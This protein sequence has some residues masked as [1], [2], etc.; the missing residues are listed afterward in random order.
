MA[1]TLAVGALA[2][3]LAATSASAQDALVLFK[4]PAKD[5]G[6]DLNVRGARPGEVV[7]LLVDDRPDPDPTKYPRIPL[8]SNADGFGIVRFSVPANEL[9][10]DHP[11]YAEAFTAELHSNPVLLREVPALYLLVDD[12]DQRT[13]VLRFD[14]KRGA[15]EPQLARL[16]ADS[17][18]AIAQAIPFAARDGALIRSGRETAAYPLN[19]GERPIDL[20]AS[21]DQSMLLALTREDLA[22]GGAVLR[23]RLIE[24][25]VASHEIASLEVLRGGG[26]LVSAWLVFHN[27]SRRALVAASD[28]AIREVV[29]G[30][31]PGKGLT[32]LP[33]S[34]QASEELLKVDIHGDQVVVVTRPAGARNRRT[35]TS[36]VLVFDLN[37]R[38]NPTETLLDAVAVDFEVAERAGGPAAFVALESG[39]VEVVPLDPDGDRVRLA[40]PE[41]RKLARAPD[42]S[43]FG[44]V[45]ARDAAVVRIDPA[46]LQIDPLANMGLTRAATQFGVFGDARGLWLYA[47]VQVEGSLTEEDQLLCAELD[48]ATGHPTGNV[49]I[50]PLGGHVRRVAQR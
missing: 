3:F 12:V 19:R 46:T 26:R 35:T 27:D 18:L 50:R 32:L 36:R 30:A 34:P 15:L 11:L 28:G 2:V 39:L 10:T 22:Q 48:P 9:T 5:G 29:L 49:V 38:S 31:E 8:F 33:L 7:Q 43:L 45:G 41:I 42:G 14:P 6:V 16:D 40:I 21:A 37:E 20:V 17:V 13:R 4:T 25:D 47:V 1:R 44:L 24:S 23:L